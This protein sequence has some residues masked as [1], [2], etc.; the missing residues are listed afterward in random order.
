VTDFVII[1][2]NGE[3]G[4]RI[5]HTTFG[6]KPD[7]SGPYTVE[8]GANWVQGL[9]TEGGPENPIWTLVNSPPSFPQSVAD[10]SRLKNG[11]SS[12]NT[13]TTHPSQVTTRPAK[14]I[15]SI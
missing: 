11:K 4:G 3:I 12:A 1:E 7:G 13:I 15:I 6:D 10:W 8:L 9:G 14:Q 5:K 2:Y